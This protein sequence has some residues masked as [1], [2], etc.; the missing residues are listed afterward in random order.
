[1][2]FFN[3]YFFIGLGVGLVLMI[4]I[5]VV[6]GYIFVRSFTSR[7]GEKIESILQPPPFPAR[8]RMDYNWRVRG[9]DG[10]ELDV[11]KTRGKVI[12]INFWATWCPPCV[13]EMPSIQ[14]L[15]DR[16][17]SEE[18]LFMCVSEEDDGKV[19]KFA[20]EMGFTFPI[21]TVV[22]EKPPVFNT[23]GI[24]ATFIIGRD[25]QIVFRHVGAAKWDHKTSI[26]F[27]RRL[28]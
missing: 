27:I 26:D 1:M 11:G 19:G 2:K 8:I 10:K 15:Y 9:L 28:M 25:G 14:R 23:R 18:I 7:S 13:A 3:K 16:I 24:P 5:I 22:D 6:G 12:F 17:K 4:A 20:K 21:Y